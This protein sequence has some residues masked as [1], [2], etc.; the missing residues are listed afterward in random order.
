MANE[1]Q[2]PHDE[3]LT[4]S[5]EENATGIVLDDGEP[6]VS[7]KAATARLKDMLMPAG[8]W[9][10][11]QYGNGFA[12]MRKVEPVAE[13]AEEALEQP[14]AAAPVAEPYKWV[15]FHSKSN[16]MDPDE[17]ILAVNGEVLQIRRNE[18]IPVAQRF[19]ECADHARY[20]HFTQEPG[21]DRKVDREIHKYPFDILGEATRDDFVRWKRAGTKATREHAE[22]VGI[23]LEA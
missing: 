23:P 18:R 20:R 10:V 1:P 15:R 5:A 3:P 12:I 8:A 17:V 6:F 4:I 14:V 19:L 11:D 22:R 7:K 16:P 13:E 2:N 9:E 21:K